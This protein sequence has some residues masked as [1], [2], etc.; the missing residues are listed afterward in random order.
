LGKLSVKAIKDLHLPGRYADGDGLYL[1]VRKGGSR[2]WLL[3]VSKDGKRHDIGLGALQYVKLSEAR[4]KTHQLK[5]QIRHGENPIVAKQKEKGIPTFEEASLHVWEQK[6]HSWKNKK[7]ANQWKNT[8]ETYAFPHFGN[9][10]VNAIR[11]ADI[12]RAIEPIW[13]LKQETAD[14]L[15]QRISSVFDWTRT[16]GFREAENPVNGIRAGL[17]NRQRDRKHHSALNWE[18]IPKFMK[19][20]R[21]RTG[22]ASL[23]L[24]F[25]ILTAARSGEIRGTRWSEIDFENAIWTIPEIRMKMKKLHRIPLSPQ[26]INVLRQ[27]KALDSEIVFPF[28]SGKTLSENA[29]RQLLH[30]ME[31][32]DITAH[33]FRST[34]RDWCSEKAHAPRE[35]AELALAHQFGDATE[36]A[37]ARS[38]QL[39]RRREIMLSWADYSE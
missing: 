10:K 22:V 24:Q 5:K 34:F 4:E 25:L 18:S 17:A 3:R 15:L 14:R 23:A 8:L 1:H 12:L 39:E 30:R 38:D 16:A 37:Y 2:Q 28:K 32:K 31:Y 36:R 35:L 27:C 7:H 6:R 11:Q 9:V 13:H 20:L 29:F 19:E 26:A 33:G 21:G